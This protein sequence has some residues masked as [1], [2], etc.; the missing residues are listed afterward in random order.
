SDIFHVDNDNSS[1]RFRFVGEADLGSWTAGTVLEAEFESNSTASINQN[2][3]SDS[4]SLKE[5][6]I[7]FFIK[8]PQYG[9]LSVGQGDT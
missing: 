6:K 9:K 5:R 8:Q 4:A 7:E 1:T 2:N 3:Q